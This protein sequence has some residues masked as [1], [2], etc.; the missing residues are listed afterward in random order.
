MR[1]LFCNYEYPPLGGGGGVINALL[2]EELATRHE[3]TVLS[4][5]GLGLEPESVV[6]GV[7][8]VRVPVFF[9]SQQAAANVPSMLTYL[10]MGIAAGKRLI[11]E[12]RYDVINTHFVLPTGPVGDR[13]AGLGKLP[14]VLSV[15]GGDLYDPS[16]WMSPHRHWVLRTWIKRL[17]H[18]ADRVVGQSR[19]T[20]ENVH[21]YYDPALSVDRIPLGIRRPS[22]E[23]A[24]RGDYGFSDEQVLL[25]TVG[26]LVARKAVDQ[27]ISVL[28]D[29]GR[30]DVHLLII[31]SGPQE[32]ALRQKTGELGLT[33][34]VHFMGQISESDKF[35][36]LQIS[37]I[38]VSTS[39]HEGFGLVFLEA[40]ASGLPVIC[41]DYGGQTDFLTDGVTGHVVPL[42]DTGQF[43][44]SCRKLISD[45]DRVREMSAG[46]RARVEEL[47]I[48][49]CA[50]QYEQ[51][52]EEVI[53]ERTRPDSGSHPG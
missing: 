22:V 11:R 27:L 33:E 6:N 4:S 31:G 24:T 5:Q 15:H 46:N 52:F 26:R 16:K 51:L 2:A 42:N 8:V 29:T 35:R 34:R 19:N 37:D 38:F 25:V 3:V 44:D 41:Y 21:T 7:R 32:Q 23:A 45:P 10:P 40:M 39:Q 17:L 1:I 13:L 53:R 43:A 9:R 50:R 36:L 49:N 47:Y 18:R 48:D 14:H 20:V 28:K 30:P 12:E